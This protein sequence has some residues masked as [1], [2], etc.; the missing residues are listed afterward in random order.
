M[1]S[2][3]KQRNQVKRLPKSL[4]RFKTKKNVKTKNNPRWTLDVPII[5][6]KRTPTHN[7]KPTSLTTT[8][9]TLKSTTQMNPNISPIKNIKVFGDE[10]RGTENA[11][12]NTYDV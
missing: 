11:K 2:T 8:P 5:D 1:T 10:Q 3:R 4:K 6:K 7:I 12:L 9:K